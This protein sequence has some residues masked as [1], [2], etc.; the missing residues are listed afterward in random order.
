MSAKAVTTA[1]DPR[2]LDRFAERD[3]ARMQLTPSRQTYEIR[4]VHR[5]EDAA[6]L[7]GTLPYR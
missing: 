3:D 5:D 6:F 7:V 1:T 2:K 4:D